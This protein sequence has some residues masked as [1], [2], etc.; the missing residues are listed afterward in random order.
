M[1]VILPGT[2]SLSVSELG[3]IDECDRL[4]MLRLV[5]D[6]CSQWKMVLVGGGRRVKGPRLDLLWYGAWLKLCNL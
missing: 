1:V 5:L 3:V 4:D 6:D 2:G